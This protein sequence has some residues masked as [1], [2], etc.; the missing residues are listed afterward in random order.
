MMRY[1]RETQKFI[2]KSLYGSFIIVLMFIYKTHKQIKIRLIW[3]L[4][5]LILF[6]LGY[7]YQMPDII[8]LFFNAMASFFA[9]SIFKK[10]IQISIPELQ[11][12]FV[13]TTFL[14]EKVSFTYLALAVLLNIFCSVIKR[15]LSF[16]KK[17]NIVLITLIVALLMTFI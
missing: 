16:L 5:A 9:F 6:N 2:S 17:V 11:V 15:N 7:S 10:Y 12:C 1:N 8:N 14:G 13:L 4:V 3:M